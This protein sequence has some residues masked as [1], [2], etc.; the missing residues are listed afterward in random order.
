MNGLDYPMVASSGKSGNYDVATSH[1][2][3]LLGTAEHDGQKLYK[4]RNPWGTET[5]SGSWSDS[6][7]TSEQ[8]EALEHSMDNDG[9][10][11]MPLEEF[12]ATY[13]NVGIN[14]YRDDWNK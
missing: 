9:I 11:Y 3:T 4:I 10:F 8:I 13:D 7:L 2:F 12:H 14:Y 6:N 1:A 5:Y